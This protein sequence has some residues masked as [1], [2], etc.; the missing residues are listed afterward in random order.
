VYRVLEATASEA[1]GL[2]ELAGSAGPQ[3][4]LHSASSILSGALVPDRQVRRKADN[5]CRSLTELCIELCGMKVSLT[6][7]VALRS[8]AA[9]PS[10]RPSVQVNGESPQVRASIEPESDAVPRSS[11]SRAMSRIEARRASLLT[12]RVNGG[13]RQSSQEPPTPSQTNFSRLNRSNTSHHQSRRQ[14][15][16][17]EDDDD[18]TLRAP[19][20]AMTDF[21]DIRAA[22]QTQTKRMS[23]DYSSKEPMP[24]LQPSPSLKYTSSLRRPTVSGH[25]NNPLQFRDGTRRYILD[26][27]NAPAYEK[28]KSADLGSRL[29]Q[30]TQY[31]PN[32]ATIGAVSALTRSGS[33]GR[34]RR[35][36]SAGE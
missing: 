21:R 11:P 33:L 16:E 20:R 18:P 6:S 19:S 1:I 9:A 3:G 34:R 2:A 26:R 10:R 13:S 29:V 30:P 23:R 8:A 5:I 28:P 36:N 35:G 27:Q 15:D 17:E 12:T 31:N 14:E 24:E 32:R 25:E 4:T 7:P 22:G